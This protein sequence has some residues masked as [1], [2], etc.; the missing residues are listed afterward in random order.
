MANKRLRSRS[1]YG[2]GLGLWVSL[3]CGPILAQAGTAVFTFGGTP[4]TLTTDADQDAY[5][6]R[7]LTKENELRAAASPPRATL[8]L[9]EYVR[10][11]LVREL[12]SRKQV[13]DTLAIEDF[14]V[15]YN[16]ASDP[17]K[18]T[19]RTIGGNN[20]PCP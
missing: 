6:T 19:V 17:D 8:T 20:S 5:L 12:A 4:L 9:E 18:T 3:T 7:L 16:A 15:S 10:D 11:A 1:W 2:V 13:A 14:C